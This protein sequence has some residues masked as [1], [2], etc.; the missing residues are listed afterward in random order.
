[1]SPASTGMAAATAAVI[2][3]FCLC[4]QTGIVEH[5]RICTGT[6]LSC[7]SKILHRIGQYNSVG[8]DLWLFFYY[9]FQSG[10]G[11]EGNESNHK[12]W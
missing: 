5:P 3:S 4:H 8:T 2:S 12:G 1:M 9:H 10:E 11:V 7:M 6:K